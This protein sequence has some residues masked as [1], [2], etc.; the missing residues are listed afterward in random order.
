[1][2]AAV[3]VVLGTCVSAGLLV[4]NKEPKEVIKE[5]NNGIYDKE[6]S[7][8]KTQPDEEKLEKISSHFKE[9]KAKQEAVLKKEEEEKAAAE[10]AKKTAAEKTPEKEQASKE[11]APTPESEEKAKPD[12]AKK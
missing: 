12:K 8:K 7:E 5:V 4:E 3:K 9:V 11:Q 10:E 2:K 6:I 1:L